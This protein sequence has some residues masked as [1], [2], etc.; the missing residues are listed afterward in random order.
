MA[1]FYSFHYDNDVTRVQQVLNMGVLEGQP[2]LNHQ[3]WEAVKLQGDDAVEDWIDQQMKYKSAIIVLI[4]RYTAS[5]R[6]VQYEIRRAWDLKRPL[7]GIRINGLAN[8]QGRV[9]SPGD[10]P[11]AS[12]NTWQTIPIFDPTIRTF[13]GIDS[14]QTYRNLAA[15]LKTWAERGVTRW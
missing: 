11:F 7:L 6:W 15:N 5:R 10:D 8:L 4:G 14:S 1:V 13:Q 9:D 3:D 12:L 2:L